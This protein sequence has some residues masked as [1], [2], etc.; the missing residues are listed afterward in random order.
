MNSSGLIST[1]PPTTI[2]SLSQTSSNRVILKIPAKRW[3][4][5]FVTMSLNSNSEKSSS[6]EGGSLMS[7]AS[8]S[9]LEDQSID[10]FKMQLGISVSP[11]R[12]IK[13]LAKIS[14]AFTSFW[15]TAVP[16]FWLQLIQGLSYLHRDYSRE[17]T[18]GRQVKTGVWLIIGSCVDTEE[19]GTKKTIIYLKNGQIQVF[20]C[21]SL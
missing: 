15:L 13:P 21:A 12:L 9:V 4:G 17:S 7:R 16:H 19:R 8:I 11:L 20:D 10:S 18:R 3:G 6:S 5:G 1:V 14:V 2:P